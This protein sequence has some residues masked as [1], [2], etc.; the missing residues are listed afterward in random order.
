M[1]TPPTLIV[2]LKN[3]DDTYCSPS[4]SPAKKSYLYHLG[5]KSSYLKTC[6]HCIAEVDK[7]R[8][9]TFKAAKHC[10]L[11]D[12]GAVFGPSLS[13]VFENDK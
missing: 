11:A 5:L 2:S 3:D 6:I 1:G 12:L 7:I 4:P 9:Q 13:Q 8:K 10:Q